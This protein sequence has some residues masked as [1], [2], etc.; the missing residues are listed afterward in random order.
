MKK[1]VTPS[2]KLKPEAERT[3]PTGQLVLRTLAMPNDTNPYGHIFGG[4]IM[5]QMDIGGAIL[6]KEIAKNRVVTASVSA[7][8]FY[9]PA[10]VGDV[11]CCYAKC[12]KTG[13][14]SI[15]IALEVWGKKITDSNLIGERTCITQAVFTYVAVDKHSKPKP[16]PEQYQRFDHLRDDISKLELSGT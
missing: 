12:L 16:L 10:L 11:I 2:V 13:T 1:T 8:S 5:S 15:T 6:A 3:Q 14:T 7:L 4:W 9:K